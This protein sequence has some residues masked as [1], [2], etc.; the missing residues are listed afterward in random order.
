MTN[1]ILIFFHIFVGV[2]EIYTLVRF[3]LLF[4]SHLIF[5]LLIFLVFIPCSRVSSRQA[6]DG[7]LVALDCLIGSPALLC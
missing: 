3:T 1:S 6:P 7:N 5:L 2:F 4:S